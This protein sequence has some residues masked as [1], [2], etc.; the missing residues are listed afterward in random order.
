MRNRTPVPRSER[1]PIPDFT[2]VP[3]KYRH[4]GW[5]PE[6]QRAFIEALADCGSVTRAAAQVNI[7][8]ANAY[9]LRR[10]PGAEEFRRAW[11]AALDFGVLRLK[12]IAFERAIEGQLVPVFVAGRLMGFRRKRNDALLMFCLR[13]YGQDASGKR[14]T[15]NYFS[16]R[17]SAG[18]SAGAAASDLPLPGRSAACPSPEG[19]GLSSAEASTTTVRTV[20][21]GPGGA[22][23]RSGDAAATLLDGF[24]GVPLDAE[25]HGA[26]AAALEACAAR[27]RAAD[28]AYECGGAAAIEAAIDATEESFVRVGEKQNPYLGELEPSVAVEEFVPFTP[29]EPFWHLAGSDKPEELLAFEARQAERDA[30][31]EADK[32]A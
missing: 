16:T 26:I 23:E 5:T 3:R 6:R 13:H 29:G 17:A 18:A 25:A 30:E 4:D 11:D 32:G 9:A 7:A 24:E 19:V 2:P 21:T 8:Q 1:P 28:A 22:D 27:A 12:D 20:I 31:E 14:T 15:I 10:A